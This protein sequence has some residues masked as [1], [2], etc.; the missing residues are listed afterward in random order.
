MMRSKYLSGHA[1]LATLVW[2]KGSSSSDKKYDGV[3]PPPVRSKFTSERPPSTL[4]DGLFF[5][6]R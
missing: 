5:E 2:G 4:K 1:L 6:Q 3:L